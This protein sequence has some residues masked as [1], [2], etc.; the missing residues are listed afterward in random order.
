[1]WTTGPVIRALT[2]CW[3]DS[4]QN[5][6]EP[7]LQ[8][9]TKVLGSLVGKRGYDRERVQEDVFELLQALAV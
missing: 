9:P 8:E 1:M 4:L 5:Q 6:I 2:A 7:L 3:A